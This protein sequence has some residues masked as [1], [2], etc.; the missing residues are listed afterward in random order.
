M[1]NKRKKTYNLLQIEFRQFLFDVLLLSSGY[2]K[3]DVEQ[4]TISFV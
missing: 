3:Y 2:E 1:M 4:D